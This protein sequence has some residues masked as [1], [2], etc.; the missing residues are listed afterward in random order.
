MKSTFYE[1]QQYAQ[2]FGLP[3][4]FGRL[5]ADDRLNCGLNEFRRMRVVAPKSERQTA[6]LDQK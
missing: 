3:A 6:T 4:Q 2:G 1:H 5:S